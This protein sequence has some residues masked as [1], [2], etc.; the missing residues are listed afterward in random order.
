VLCAVGVHH[1]DHQHDRPKP[2]A[3]HAGANFFI[4]DTV[5]HTYWLCSL[6]QDVG[7]CSNSIPCAAEAVKALT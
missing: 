2:D 7:F 1:E 3:A 5:L 4:F 6:D